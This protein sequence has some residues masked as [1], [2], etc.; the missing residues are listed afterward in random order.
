MLVAL[1]ALLALQGPN[2]LSAA[3]TKGGWRL[4]FDGKTTQGWHNFKSDSIRPGW[5]VKD[6]VLTCAEPENAGDIVSNDKF[7][8]FELTLDFNLSK[9]GN[10]GVMF[11]VAD[12]GDATWHSGPEVQ[13][14]DHP[15]DGQNQITG[16]LYEIYPGKKDASKPAGEWNTMRIVVSPKKCET[17]VNGVKY[18]EYVLG[19]PDFKARVAKS[20]FAEMPNFA[21]VHKGSIAI[22]GDHG[23]VSFRNVKIRPLRGN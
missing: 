13:L 17:F 2:S 21:K 11:H 19:S 1:S 7:E 12:D 5:V 6:G 3:E 16:W 20:K 22:Q 18:Y 8:W 23:V 15:M 9:G 14:Y 4:L 10:S